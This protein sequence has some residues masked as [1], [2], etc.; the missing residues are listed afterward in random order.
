MLNSK[1]WYLYMIE[2]QDQSIYTGIAIDV[3]ARYQL[4][5]SGKG[6]RYTRAH[7]PKRLIGIAEYPDR[8]TAAKAEHAVK[9]LT[10]KKKR[11]FALSLA[12]ISRFGLNLEKDL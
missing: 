4:H 6:A 5:E 7:P 2:C 11:E 8:S 10:S 12:S 1:P 9:Q 3:L